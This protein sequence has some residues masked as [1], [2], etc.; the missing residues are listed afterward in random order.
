MKVTRFF[1][2]FVSTLTLIVLGKIFS[3]NPWNFIN[4]SM[5]QTIVKSPEIP[6]AIKPCLP[7]GDSIK[8]I[9]IDG[10]VEYEGNKYYLMGIIE[11]KPTIFENDTEL[12]DSGTIILEDKIGC[13]IKQ[14]KE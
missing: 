11:E 8:K 12:V 1:A 10:I 4:S 14:P 13:L 6:E 3:L 2:I 7:K 5:A 9:E